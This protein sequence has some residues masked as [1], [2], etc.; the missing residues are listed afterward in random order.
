VA[1]EL[2]L[3]LLSSTFTDRCQRQVEVTQAGLSRSIERLEAFARTVLPRREADELMATCQCFRDSATQVGSHVGTI[4]PMVDSGDL[5]PFEA[6]AI[7]RELR[8]LL[9][10]LE[11]LS[12]T[13]GELTAVVAGRVRSSA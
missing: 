2:L 10:D 7:E 1:V 9:R 11:H 13:A 4:G 12:T 5:A 3:M 6:A 8:A